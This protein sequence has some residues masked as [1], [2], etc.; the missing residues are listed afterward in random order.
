MIT[1]INK[2]KK[3]HKKEYKKVLIQI[4]TKTKE[5]EWIDF[6]F[7]QIHGLKITKNN[8]EYK[9]NNIIEAR[10][11]L[12]DKELNKN[13]LD[14][15]RKLLKIN[16]LDFLNEADLEKIKASLT[17]FD[18]ITNP[19]I[20]ALLTFRNYDNKLLNLFTS[21][22]N[23][24]IFKKLLDKFFNGELDSSTLLLIES[25]IFT[26]SDKNTI[27]KNIEKKELK[28]AEE[29]LIKYSEITSLVVDNS[30][31]N[32]TKIKEFY[33][34]LS[35]EEYKLFSKFNI[36]KKR[37]KKIKRE[38][39][40]IQNTVATCIVLFVF[41]T[42]ITIISLKINSSII[43]FQQE[44]EYSKLSNIQDETNDEINK[45][46]ISFIEEENRKA[47]EAKKAEEERIRKEQEEAPKKKTPVTTTYNY[48]E[49]TGIGNQD[50]VNIA[51]AQVGNI[52]GQPFWSWYGFTSRVEWCG[53]FVSWVANQA[54]ISESIIPKFAR[55]RDG[56]N[57]F[58][59]RQLFRDR[60]YV[61]RAGDLIF[62]DYDYN[63]TVDHVGIVKTVSGGRVYTI[64]GN[65][66]ND[67]CKELSYTI[68]HSHIYGYGTPN[69]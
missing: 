39:N 68:G 10:E 26:Y 38:K 16:N 59:N 14:I 31:G 48:V 57:W 64:E 45:I 19:N 41:L 43:I 58:I 50:M 22:K 36:N 5:T 24:T 35:K 47:E 21:N 11:Y 17:L 46:T 63:G 61:P 20:K 52:G 25:E 6:I 18:Y 28:L 42:S 44:S 27:L 56:S 1:N 9:F 23:H 54:G 67:Q 3:I 30:N 2:Y 37:I 32:T 60:N 34:N 33:K 8:N 49:P 65:V 69:Y 53:I 29:I 40:K 7:P 4:K 15:C 55:A 62:Y 66:K 12:N 13:L 51:A